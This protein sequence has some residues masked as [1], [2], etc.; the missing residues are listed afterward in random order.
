MST[1]ILST[2]QGWLKYKMHS[3][4]VACSL[5]CIDRAHAISAALFAG[6]LASQASWC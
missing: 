4:A 3:A 2:E 6:T 1:F 5:P